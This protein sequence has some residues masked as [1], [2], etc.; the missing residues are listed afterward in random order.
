MNE[1]NALKTAPPK[2]VQVSRPSILE[3]EFPTASYSYNEQIATKPEITIQVEKVQPE[4]EKT[5]EQLAAEVKELEIKKQKNEE[6]AKIQELLVTF[7][8]AP[9]PAPESL[10]AEKRLTETQIVQIEAIF[11][12]RFCRI[13]Q[14]SDT[15]TKIAKNKLADEEKLKKTINDLKDDV[16]STL[17]AYKPHIDKA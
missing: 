7:K 11:G 15:L 14:F 9:K 13:E 4:E 10:L 5:I 17:K 8:K 2:L 12:Q 16:Q 3:V 1:L 6:A